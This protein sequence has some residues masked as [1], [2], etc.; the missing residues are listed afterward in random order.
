M[1]LLIVLLSIAVYI[2]GWVY[3]AKCVV[4][5]SD[6]DFCFAAAFM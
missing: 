4:K 2:T 6:A 1:T 5:D 3:A